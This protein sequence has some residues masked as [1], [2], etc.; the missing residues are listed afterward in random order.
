MEVADYT[1][2]LI[3]PSLASLLMKLGIWI[4]FGVGIFAAVVA[5]LIV[6][7][8]PET[9]PSR[10]DRDLI[11]TPQPS[12][13]EAAHVH[14]LLDDDQHLFSLRYKFEKNAAQCSTNSEIDH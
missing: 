6:F 5:I 13:T 7:I 4:P 9:A 11:G 2:Q 10:L 3:A 8:L 1:T 12:A 14:D